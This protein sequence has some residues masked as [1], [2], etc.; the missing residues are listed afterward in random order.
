VDWSAV[1]ALIVAAVP[2]LRLLHRETIGDAVRLLHLAA[3]PPGGLVVSVIERRLPDG[4]QTLGTQV[5]VWDGIGH[6]RT[7]RAPAVLVNTTA[8]SVLVSAGD[9]TTAVR[10][11]GP[12]AVEAAGVEVPPWP[13]NPQKPAS[14]P[15]PG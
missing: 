3:A 15:S 5:L 6:I 10:L 13:P 14:R 9:Q 11:D 1:E 2:R 7:V 4:W 12:T 8:T